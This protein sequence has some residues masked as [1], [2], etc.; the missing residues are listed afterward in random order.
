MTHSLLVY[1]GRNRAATPQ[2]RHRDL[3]V[4]PFSHI[5]SRTKHDLGFFNFHL[6]SESVEHLSRL[7]GTVRIPSDSV[8]GFSEIADKRACEIERLSKELNRPSIFVFWSGG[9]DSTAA[10]VGLLRN[11]SK[12]GLQNLTVVLTVQSILENPAFYVETVSALKTL[13]YFEAWPRLLSNPDALVVTGELGDQIMGAGMLLASY[14]EYGADFLA[15]DYRKNGPQALAEF[16]KS[17]TRRVSIDADKMFAFLRPIADEAPIQIRSVFDFFWW[18]NF[19]QEWQFAK[20]KFL[21]TAETPLA[22]VQLSQVQHYFD[23]VDFQLW[24][25]STVE[26]RLPKSWKDYK[27]AAKAY[28]DSYSKQSSSQGLIKR[29][30]LKHTYFLQKF[31]QGVSAAFESVD[32][33]VDLEKYMRLSTSED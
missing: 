7:H 29:Q 30:S 11:L 12:E 1:T 23:T 18:F 20:L 6:V 5:I 13:N 28:I 32:E 21:E 17:D 19:T 8:I 16:F 27:R 31:R 3:F 25:I 2:L 15:S 10:L 26:E 24:S 9:I 14:K 33:K 22:G 4:Y